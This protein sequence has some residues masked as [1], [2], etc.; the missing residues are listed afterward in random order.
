[1]RFTSRQARFTSCIL[2][3]RA[4]RQGQ[5]LTAF[6]FENDTYIFN[7]LPVG[8]APSP[9]HLQSVLNEVTRPVAKKATLLWTH[10]D[11]IIFLAPPHLISALLD[12]LLRAIHD[13][14]F[15]IN[16]KKSQLQPSSAIDYL[17]IH[18]DLRW[19]CFRPSDTHLRAL[20]LLYRNRFAR[21]S[22]A[23]VRTVK[24][25][26]AFLLSLT[27]RQYA[28]LRQHEADTI[29]LL[30]AVWRFN[31]LVIPLRPPRKPPY[32]HVDAILHLGP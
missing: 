22:P 18:I 4:S 20:A 32:V 30:Y 24:G 28:L 11:D 19:R 27:L 14:G 2:F 29:R 25:F 12:E 31:R 6:R 1:M 15:I 16:L 9:G 23:E 13:A 10:V 3:A 17:G 26:L 8:L 5:H 7:R 21:R